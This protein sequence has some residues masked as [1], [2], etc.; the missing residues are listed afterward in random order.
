METNRS[1]LFQP[2]LEVLSRVSSQ[3]GDLGAQRTLPS[4]EVD[5]KSPTLQV[6]MQ[7][8]S[9][10]PDPCVDIRTDKPVKTEDRDIE[11]SR[12]SEGKKSFVIRPVFEISPCSSPV[13]PI[14]LPEPSDIQTDGDCLSPPSRE[15]NNSICS[16]NSSASERKKSRHVQIC[17]PPTPDYKKNKES[18]DF[19]TNNEE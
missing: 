4:L 5:V 13:P 8:L 9:I 12:A 2:R 1:D 10:S 15:S 3:Y 14:C 16:I 6:P 11:A 19:S 7:H 17:I 18:F